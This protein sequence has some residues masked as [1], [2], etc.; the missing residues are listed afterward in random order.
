MAPRF[1]ILP[2]LLLF[3]LTFGQA[4]AAS[5]RLLAYY[6]YGDRYN[7]IPYSA[8][9]IPYQQLTHISHSA[10]SPAAQADG[11]LDV[12]SGFLEPDLISLAHAANV[13]VV[14]SV[15]GDPNVFVTIDADPAL[16]AVFAQNLASFAITNGYDGVDFDYEVP[17]DQTEATN[18]TSLIQDTR[19]LLP[20]GQYLLTAAVSSTPGSYGLYD[21]AGMIPLLDFFNVMT[22]DFHGPWTNHSGH[23]SPL[24]L[25]PNDPG[26][27]GSL[28]TSVDAYLQTFKVPAGQINLGTAFYGYAFNV[29]QLWAFCHNQQLCGNNNTPS[30]TYAQIEHGIKL[31]G[32]TEHWD[33]LADAPY[34]LG[35]VNTKEGFIT[36]DNPT[37]TMLKVHYALNLRHLGGV[38][39]WEISQDY[40]GR[41][42][43]L[44]TAMYKA[45]REVNAA[46]GVHRARRRWLDEDVSWLMSD[47]EASPFRAAK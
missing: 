24:F 33:K 10:I 18:F 40:N 23:N 22:Y 32:W 42:Q 44:M 16:R 17:N 39:M 20:A 4:H 43:P 38:F 6:Y 30:F 35:P 31:F 21:F 41:Q 8:V 19:N 28:E 7:S 13:K 29:D 46:A 14:V 5:R 26:Q 1:R 11:S 25:N 12:P 27:E 9:N 37:S 15:G 2:A 34:L 3:A 36:Y 45:F 47:E